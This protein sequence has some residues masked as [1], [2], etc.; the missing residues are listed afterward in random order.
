MF[1]A[2]CS[3]KMLILV[4]LSVLWFT[5]SSNCDFEVVQGMLFLIVVC[6][7]SMNDSG[8]KNY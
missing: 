7:I 4:Q 8:A 5:S 2:H 6:I 3:V 1:A